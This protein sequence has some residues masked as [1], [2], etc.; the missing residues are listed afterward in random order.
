MSIQFNS[1]PFIKGLPGLG[2]LLGED[3]EMGE[4]G[5]AASPPGASSLSPHSS[6]S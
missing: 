5:I 1:T 4:W 3:G 6:K 2:P